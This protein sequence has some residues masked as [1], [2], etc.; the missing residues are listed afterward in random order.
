M[1][2][3]DLK[4]AADLLVEASELLARSGQVQ[5]AAEVRNIVERLELF[6]PKSRPP[7]LSPMPKNKVMATAFGTVNLCL[8]A[9]EP[10][11]L[12][13]LKGQTSCRCRRS[14]RRDL[15]DQISQGGCDPVEW[16]FRRL[17]FWVVI[18]F[19]R[20]DGFVGFRPTEKG[21]G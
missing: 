6:I 14:P 9:N 12:R 20:A 7:Y 11:K 18:G 13:R 21:F 19:G 15:L 2:T 3:R 8:L 16:L 4:E 1:Q 5:L 17:A 10:R